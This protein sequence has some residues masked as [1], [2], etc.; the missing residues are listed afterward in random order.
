M[1]NNNKII[2]KQLF[3][4]GLPIFLQSTLQTMLPMIDQIMVG[5]LGNDV[6]AAIGISGN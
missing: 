3:T 5:Q 4:I 6:I 2:I 1:S